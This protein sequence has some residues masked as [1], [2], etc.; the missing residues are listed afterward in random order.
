[1]PRLDEVFRLSGI[2]TYTFVEPVRYDEIKVSLRTPGRC[3]VMEG[4]SGIGK[5]TTIG[6]AIT[7]LGSQGNTMSLSTRRQGDLEIINA[8]PDLEDIGTVIVDDFHRLPA[9]TKKRLSDFMKRLADSETETS[10]LVLI[11]INKAGQ[12]L[13]RFAG[14]LGLRFDVFRLEA[15]PVEKIHELITLGEDALSVKFTEKDAI[16]ARAQGSFQIAQLLCHKLCIL[17]KVFETY[18][19]PTTIDLSLDVVIE[20]VMVDLGRQFKEVA[21]TFA[22]GSKLRREGRAPY[23]HMLKWLAESEEWSLDLSDALRRRPEHRAS[24][25]QVLEKGYLKALL[26]DADKQA[27]LEPHFHFEPST[28]ILSVEDPKLI[29]YLKNLIWRAFT[30]Q[31]GFTTDYFVHK[32]DFALSFA[33]ADRPHARRLYE[34]LTEREI[35]TFF[36]ENEQF[37]IIARN[38]EDYLVPIYKSEARYVV[39]FLSPDYPSRIWTKIESDQF[40]ERFGDNAVVPIRFTTAKPNFFS[41]EQKYGGLSFD[42]AAN[43]EAQLEEIAS[44]L[45][46]RLREDRGGDASE[47]DSVYEPKML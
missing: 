13:L 47:A 11:G 20:D 46:K 37:R 45:A 39:A 19:H 38:V 30:R 4:P 18:S 8:L 9:K 25:S 6:K 21:L 15:N 2:P 40:K 33:G 41:D 12:Q 32:Y 23:L 36:D 29:F 28:S 42:P 26:R 31:V 44:T 27:I 1:M 3:L 24:I 7:D 34:M 5:S 16:A 10:K 17:A 22:R 14:D 43:T 35:A